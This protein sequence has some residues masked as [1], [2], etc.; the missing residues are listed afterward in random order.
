LTV[1]LLDT[2]ILSEVRRVRPHGAVLAWFDSVPSRQLFV[3]AVV[4]GELQAGAEITRRQDV[5]KAI[6]IE[7]WIDRIM[8]TFQVISMDA[9][10]FREWAKLMQ[11]RSGTLYVDA[12]IAGTA[13][14]YGYTVATR[15]TGDFAT[16]QVPV[17]NPFTFHD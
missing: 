5:A 4:A 3:P 15:N 6:E 1:Y 13:R 10:C 14:V 16:F 17:F 12:M 11:A 7:T 2:N 8:T 9:H